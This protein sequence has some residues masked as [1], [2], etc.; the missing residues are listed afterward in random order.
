MPLRPT[1]ASFRATDRRKINPEL[2][3]TNRKWAFVE[4]VAHR[5]IELMERYALKEVSEVEMRR[6]KSMSAS[7]PEC[8][9]RP[10]EEVDLAASMHSS[11]VATV[12]KIVKAELNGTAEGGGRRGCESRRVIPDGVPARRNGPQCCPIRHCSLS[13]AYDPRNPPSP[14]K[15]FLYVSMI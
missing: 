6:A 13:V 7:C 3:P 1:Q 14:A 11:T 12:R 8:E 5:S 9:D 4:T 2:Y 15:R 10:K